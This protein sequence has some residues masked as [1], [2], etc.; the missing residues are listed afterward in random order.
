MACET[1]G[2]EDYRRAARQYNRIT[3]LCA[4]LRADV[5]DGQF[6]RLSHQR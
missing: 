3:S 2:C 6:G 4:G 1:A 5:L